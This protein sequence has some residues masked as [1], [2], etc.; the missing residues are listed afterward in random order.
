MKQNNLSNL[1]I[2]IVCPYRFV[3]AFPVEEVVEDS[4]DS[5]DWIRVCSCSIRPSCHY[6]TH[7]LN[8]PM[9]HPHFHSHY[10]HDQWI[11]WMRQQNWKTADPSRKVLDI[12]LVQILWIYESLQVQCSPVQSPEDAGD[13]DDGSRIVGGPKCHCDI[14]LEV[15]FPER[16]VCVGKGVRI[17]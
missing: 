14:H 15:F 3:D 13:E 16:Q 9:S 1:S 17:G 2:C 8:S 5:K 4:P 7:Y 6:S 10:D 12:L 11:R